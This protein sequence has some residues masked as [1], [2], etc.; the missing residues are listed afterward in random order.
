[1][2]AAIILMAKQSRPKLATRVLFYP[3]TDASFDTE[4][5]QRFA[6]GYFPRPDRWF[7]GPVRR[8]RARRDHGVAA[9]PVS[10][11]LA[12]RRKALVIPGEAD[13][14]RDEGRPTVTSC[15]SP[16]STS[17]PRATRASSTTS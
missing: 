9:A 12:G 3:I 17:P 2:S 4:S 16:A 11:C 10:D 5:Y 15:A 6:Q 1:M 14:L 8:A 13:V 7:L